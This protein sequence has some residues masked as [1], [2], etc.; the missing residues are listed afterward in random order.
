MWGSNTFGP[1][2][3]A[4]DPISGAGGPT[5]AAGG[6]TSA[7]G[8]PISTRAVRIARPDAQHMDAPAKVAA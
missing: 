7:A 3:A 1:I 5:S 6:P 2:S 8:G 4:G